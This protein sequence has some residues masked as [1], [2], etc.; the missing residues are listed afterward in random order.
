MQIQVLSDLHL[1]VK[2]FSLFAKPEAEVLVL[3]GDIIALGN[4]CVKIYHLENLIKKVKIPVVFITGNHEYYGFGK[5]SYTNKVIKTLEQKYPHFHFLDNESWIYK[6]VEFIGSTLWSDFDLAPNKIWFCGA[7]ETAINDFMVILSDKTPHGRLS[8]HEM[9]ALNHKARAFIGNAVRKANGL[10]K[11]VVTHFVPT[12]QSVSEFYKG[13]QLNPYFVCN[14]EDLMVGVH[15]FIHG[16]THTSF[17]YMLT[18]FDSY[19]NKIVNTHIVCN[20]RG[21]DRENKSGFESQ[22]IIEV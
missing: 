12:E 7:V 4:D 5:I 16:H 22:K 8:A 13:N 14:C 1:E 11:V 15:T 20:P 17:D 10:K 6:D 21:Y 18:K 19:G 2:P 3:A 9:I